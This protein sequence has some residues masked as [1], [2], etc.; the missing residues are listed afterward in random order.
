MALIMRAYKVELDPNNRQRSYFGRCCGAARFVYNWG[1]AEWKRQYEA[2]SKPSAYS[3]RVQFNAQKDDLCP[4]IRELPYAVT[5]SAFANLGRAFEN[6]FRKIKAGDK[7]GYP[8][9]KKRGRSG[10]FQVRNTKVESDRV[11]LTGVGWVRLRQPDYIPTE[12]EKY[13]VY[14]TVSER[15]GRWFIS[16]LAYQPA[17]EPKPL[18]GVLGVDVGIKSL[19]VSS[20]G[21]FYLNPKSTQRYEKKLA[22]LSRELSRRKLGGKNREKTKRAISKLHFKIANIRTNALHHASSCIVKKRSAV[23]VLEDLNVSGILKNHKIARA[24]SDAAV[25]ELQ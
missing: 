2:G 9:F 8:K 7:S 15:A 16:V 18:D 10:S 4:W 12:V 3:L 11:R 17:P 1:L 14:A 25:S 20:D 21:S 22:R 23:I 6:F 5:E 13:G 24:M 19:A